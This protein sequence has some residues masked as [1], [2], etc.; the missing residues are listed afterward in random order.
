MTSGPALFARFAYP[1]NSRHLCGPDDPAALLEAIGDVAG[2]AEIRARAAGF[3]GAW[4]YLQLIA[5]ALGLADPLDVRVVTAY[6][7]GGPDLARVPPGLL[8]RDLG[9][10]FGLSA[11]AVLAGGRPHHNLHVF[12]VYPFAGLLRGDTTGEPLRV[13][14]QCRI[15]PGVVA[16]VDAEMAWVVSDRLVWDGNKLSTEP[17]EQ[18]VRW[19]QNGYA[20][21]APPTVG[22]HVALHWDWVSAPITALHRWWINEETRRHLAIANQSLRPDQLAVG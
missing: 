12:A 22:T 9:D 2:E 20:L 17:T 19:R 3:A 16:Q 7:I 21:T 5:G 8:A 4:P 15:R 11:D 1:P 10:R 14:D 6:W 13:L 18:K